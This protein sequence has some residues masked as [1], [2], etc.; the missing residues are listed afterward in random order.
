MENV[1]PETTKYD[2]EVELPSIRTVLIVKYDSVRQCT[3]QL[4]ILNQIN[5]ESK[6][7]LTH[8]LT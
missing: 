2:K 5:S 1:D 3:T 4:K 6:L 7:N 8:V